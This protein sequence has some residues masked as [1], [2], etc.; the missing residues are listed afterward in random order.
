[1]RR[2]YRQLRYMNDDNTYAETERDGIKAMI[3]AYSW[4]GGEI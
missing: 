1:M 2:L 3:E 4:V